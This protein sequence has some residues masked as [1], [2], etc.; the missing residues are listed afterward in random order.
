MV[1]FDK[2]LDRDLAENGFATLPVLEREAVEQLKQVYLL[3]TT[4]IFEGFHPTMFHKSSAY[5]KKM[6]VLILKT[7]AKPLSTIV[8]NQFEM[9]YGNFMV[10]E[11]NSLSFMKLHQDWTYVD[12]SKYRSYAIWIPLID[13]NEKNGA[14]SV[15]PKSHNLNN[16]V[17]GPGTHC[18]LEMH[19]EALIKKYGK[20]LHLKAGEAVIWDHKLAHYSPHNQSEDNRIAITAILVPKNAHVVHYFKDS[21]SNNVYEYPVSDE[22][23]MHYQIGNKPNL[24]HTKILTE[25]KLTLSLEDF[26]NLLK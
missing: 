5:R 7:M 1:L 11:A 2:K 17:R 12:E 6:N 24:S 9:L 16:L 14:F 4:D 3:S 22:F 13:L 18:P 26:Q 25:K 10:K 15:I 8:H 20:S 21:N 19:Q 23:F